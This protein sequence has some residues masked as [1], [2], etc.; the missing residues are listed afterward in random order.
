M[1]VR[2]AA[3][4]TSRRT[5]EFLDPA[6]ASRAP[7]AAAGLRLATAGPLHL[8]ATVRVLQR[9]P[10]NPVEVWAQGRYLRMFATADGHVLT[11]V[12]NRGSIDAP[13]VRCT[14]L[15]GAPSTA[16]RRALAQRLRAT[17]GL[18]IDAVPLQ[19]AAER[20][21]SLRPTA[22]A[23]R[24][25]RPPRFPELFDAFVNVI[26]FQQLS[27]DAGAAIVGRLVQRFGERMQHADRSFAIYPSAGVIADARVA[28]LIACGLSR[29]KA[30]ALR[31]V[32][33]AVSNGD[34]T[35]D[36]IARLDT[37]DA[38]KALT[39]LPGIGP[40]S[41]AVLLLRGFGR[42]EVFPPGD[43]GALRGLTALL[44]LRSPASLERVVERFGAYRGYLYF[45][46][47]GSSLL[48]K[49]LIQPAPPP[50]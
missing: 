46:G 13:D 20:V 32:A 10:A 34:V 26:P 28:G 40:W 17:L 36:A 33:R 19:R 14:V 8:E 43:S 16:T 50:S 27:L 4:T 47:L 39:E 49:G 25:M 15:A 9:R 5:S 45:C 42:L 6:R 18:D 31:H 24:G 38:L 35:E 21:P 37:G 41:A 1:K 29:S 2:K 7:R 44:K 48:A 30:E 12:Q 3:R 11:A 22:L 23:L